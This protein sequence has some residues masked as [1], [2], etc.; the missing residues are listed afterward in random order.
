MSVMQVEATLPAKNI[1]LQEKP[2]PKSHVGKS[3]GFL[4]GVT[5]SGALVGSQM[6]TL[7]TIRGKKNMLENMIARGV[8]LD[9]VYPRTVLRNE[10]GKPILP[11]SG[12]TTRT[13]K[14]VNSFKRELF[15]WGAGIVVLTTILGS[16]ADNS[17]TKVNKKELFA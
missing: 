14:I 13:T 6:N 5:L 1:C 15:G 12:V 4:S 9:K 7:K 2:C 3:F 11:K 10:A 8:K 16:L 17:I